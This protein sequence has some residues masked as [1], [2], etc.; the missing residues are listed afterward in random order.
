M[1]ALLRARFRR[2]L[3]SLEPASFDQVIA[4]LQTLHARNYAP[5]ALGAMILSICGGFR[6]EA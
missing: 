1:D 2:Y 6:V 4:D 5:A 3:D